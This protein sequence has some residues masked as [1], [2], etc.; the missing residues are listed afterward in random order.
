MC[1]SF[2][3]GFSTLAYRSAPASDL[4][5]FAYSGLIWSMV[6]TWIVWG[7]APQ[8]STLAGAAI[9]ASSAVL[10]FVMH[11]RGRMETR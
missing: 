11:S 2:A 6:V 3:V 5:P 7:A 10:L 8:F 1:S 9:V 4:S